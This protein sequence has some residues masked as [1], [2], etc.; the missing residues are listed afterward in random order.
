[1]RKRKTFIETRAKIIITL[2][3]TTKVRTLKMLLSIPKY[4]SMDSSNKMKLPRTLTKATSTAT[5][6]RLRCRT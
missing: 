3:S 5:T 1:M 2:A 6:L 4:P